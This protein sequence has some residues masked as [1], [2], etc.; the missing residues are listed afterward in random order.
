MAKIPVYERRID[1][2][3][4]ILDTAGGK[5]VTGL[6]GTK[7]LTSSWELRI[8]TSI[9]FR[10]GCIDKV[11]TRH[12]LLR[13][14]IRHRQED[15]YHDPLKTPPLSRGSKMHTTQYVVNLL[16]VMIEPNQSGRHGDQRFREWSSLRIPRE[17]RNY[18]GL[19]LGKNRGGN[20]GKDNV[21][22]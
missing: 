19:G 9:L 10:R 16:T 18:D 11:E 2:C 12:R 15:R 20:S 17:G 3:E 14:Q 21:K 5:D 22:K 1:R 7:H 13:N 8:V 6:K 4:V